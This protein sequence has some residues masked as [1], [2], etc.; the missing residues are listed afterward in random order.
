MPVSLRLQLLHRGD[1]VMARWKHNGLARPY[2]R[3]YA[4]ESAGWSVHWRGGSHDL[5][6]A[7]VQLIAPETAYRGVG[8]TPMRHRWWHFALDGLG[9]IPPGIWSI[10]RD[11]ALTAVLAG[12][13]GEW[14][15]QTLLMHAFS[16]LPAGAIEVPRGSPPVVAAL[17]LLANSTDTT[18]PLATLAAAAG[19]HAHSLLRRFRAETG[20]SPHAWHLRHRIA[21]ACL[22]LEQS[23]D[24]I[25]DIAERYGFCDRHHFSRV[26]TRYRSV[27]PAAY[28]RTA[29]RQTSG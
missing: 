18:V 8:P 4:N 21:L 25:E 26:F 16:L 6:P 24:P 22:D 17:H 27:A 28:R 15:G 5:G 11:A 19:C 14:T 9:V 23:D 1:G 3:L 20:T 10:P 2:W 29:G 12:P 13:V 7:S